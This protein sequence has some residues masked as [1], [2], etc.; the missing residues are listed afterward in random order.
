MSLIIDIMCN[1][2]GLFHLIVNTIYDVHLQQ[3]H[4]TEG[5]VSKAVCNYCQFRVGLPLWDNGPCEFD[6]HRHILLVVHIRGCM[7][8]QMDSHVNPERAGRHSL[9]LHD[10]PLDLGQPAYRIQIYCVSKTLQIP[11]KL[12]STKSRMNKIMVQTFRL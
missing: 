10:D 4:G 9:F 5:D 1:K 12:Y 11:S 3:H 7:V 6:A 2:C 8:G